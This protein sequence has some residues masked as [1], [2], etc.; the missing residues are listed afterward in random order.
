MICMYVCDDD[1]L[2]GYTWDGEIP[3]VNMVDKNIPNYL[4]AV[5]D[6]IYVFSY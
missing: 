1:N 3:R 6:V 4:I 5:D 2:A